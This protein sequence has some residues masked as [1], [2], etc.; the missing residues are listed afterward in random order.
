MKNASIH[1]DKTTHWDITK[2]LHLSKNCIG[3]RRY[4]NCLFSL[5]PY[6]SFCTVIEYYGEL[7]GWM[8]VMHLNA[9]A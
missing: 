2:R 5:D 9:L 7:F 3:P 8:L 4:L 1:M 6:R